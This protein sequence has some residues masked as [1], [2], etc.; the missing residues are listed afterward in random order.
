LPEI[1][2]VS[3]ELLVRD[4]QE[5]R[6]GEFQADYLV[7]V[8]DGSLRW[9]RDHS[10]P[11]FEEETGLV[12]SVGILTD[13]TGRK[14]AE[15]AL[16][17]SE[18]RLRRLAAKLLTVQE[19]ERALIAKEL[20]DSI[21]QTL[22][23]IKYGVENALKGVEAGDTSMVAHSL[24]MVI[25]M[26][27]NAIDDVRNIYMGLH[28]SIL[29]DFGIIATIEW[30]CGEFEAI[31]PRFQVQRVLKVKE[32]EI[33][34]PLK[35]VIF[36]IVQTAMENVIMHS[37]SNK[38]L[39][40]LKK[41]SGLLELRIEDDG[42]GFDLAQ[43]MSLDGMAP[44]GIGLASMKERTELSGGTFLVESKKGSGTRIRAVWPSGSRKKRS[45]NH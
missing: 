25:P 8:K 3:A 7:Q 31:Y 6:T 32:E 13:V 24:R 12:G 42:I 17:E 4:R 23:A 20:H 30:L 34:Q 19:E 16:Q 33:A 14:R 28:P 10:F 11:W 9:L 38:V 41:K 18:R 5:G 27:Q 29:D 35:L 37:R 26:L 22:A 1:G 43:V 2:C 45:V 21:S 39:L 36:R 40:S 15:E 44:K